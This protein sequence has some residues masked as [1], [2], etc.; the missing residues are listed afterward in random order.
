MEYITPLSPPPNYLIGEDFNARHEVFE[1]DSST[2]NGGAA[3]ARWAYTNSAE[4]IREPRQATHRAGY[5]LDLSFA[6]IPFTQTVIVKD[7]N[8][9]LDH[10]T[11]VISIPCNSILL[12]L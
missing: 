11:L 6:N 5:V 8:C 4:Y 7:M 10:E 12:R 3:L 1:L 9:G 2:E